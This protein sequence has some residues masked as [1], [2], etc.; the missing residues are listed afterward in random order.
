MKELHHLRNVAKGHATGTAKAEKITDLTIRYGDL[1]AH[2]RSLVEGCANSVE[3]LDE[4]GAAGL[5]QANR[6]SDR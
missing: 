6:A 5:L 2:F 3:R 4:L 1:R